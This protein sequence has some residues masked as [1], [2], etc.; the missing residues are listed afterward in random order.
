MQQP[1]RAE[2]EDGT[3]QRARRLLEE[4]QQAIYRRTDRLFSGLLIFQWLASIG[5][6][7]WISPQTWIGQV[8]R[9]HIHVWAAIFLGA[10]IISLPVY[11]SVKAPGRTSTRHTIAVAQMLIGALLIHLTGGR[12]ETH[13]HVFGS[14][15]LL[16]F[17]RDWRV[18]VTGSLVVAADH[19][20]R[21]VLW[22]QSVFGVF[23]ASYWRWVE[24]TFWVTFEDVFLINSCIRSQQEM[25]GIAEQ[26]AMLE[27][28]NE[29]VEAAV[30]ERTAE[31]DIS[32]K[33]FRSLS[34]ASPVGIL[35]VDAAGRS[36]YANERWQAITGRRFADGTDQS[37][38]VSLHLDDGAATRQAWDHCRARGFDFA[39]EAR[40]ATPAGVVRWV[41]LQ[42]KPLF[43]DAAELTGYVIVSEDITERKRVEEQ[44]VESEEQ[45]R[46]AFDHAPIGMALASPAG[47][48]IRVN[49]VLCEFTGYTEQ[50]LLATTF[51][52]I[53]HPD[54]LADDM[55][56]VR[57]MLAD[58]IRFYRIEKRYFHKQGHTVWVMLN[59]SLIRDAQGDPLHFIAEIEDIT[60]RKTVE[61]ELQW[62]RDAALESARLKSEFL[63]NMS[64]E[65]RTPM[66]G[67]IGMTRLALDTD[68]DPEQRDYLETAMTSA[69]SLLTIIND[70]LD[71]SK[72]EAG[73][74]DID[75]TDFS[76]R[77]CIVNTIKP[78][79]V[80]AHA[81]HLEVNLDIAADVPDALAGDPI[82]VGQIIA[83]LAS[84]AIKFTEAG[85]VTLQVKARQRTPQDI[86]MH[87]V[88][89][90]T[91]IGIRPE[92]QQIIF[93]SFTQ[94]DGS[95][96]RKYG[97]TGLGLAISASLVKLMGGE[98]WVESHPG[99]GSEFHFTLNFGIV[100]SEIAQTT[101][102]LPASLLGRR[103][104]VVDD[105]ATNRRILAHMLADWGMK[106]A[107]AEDGQAALRMMQEALATGDPFSLIMVDSRMPGMDG[108]AV[109]EQIRKIP[110]FEEAMMMMLTSAQQND[111]ISRCKQLG[112][113]AY[114][115]KP[116]IESALLEAVLKTLGRRP[117]FNR[118][119]VRATDGQESPNLRRMRVLLV[120]DNLINQ[121]VATRLLEKR[122]CA[123]ELAATGKEAL[124]A[125][126]RQSFDIILM[127][128][129]MPD[130]NGFEAT[131]AIRE[132]EKST[133]SHVPI[134]AMTAHVM[135]GDKER[136]LET[137]MDGY[138]SKPIR[139]EELFSTI[140]ELVFAG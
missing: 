102:A 80:Q 52:A 104:L 34:A 137:G 135:K 45:F 42:A 72:I 81:K 46:K 58:E 77:E 113:G 99:E 88:F 89:S 96:T 85:E 75:C 11:L 87:F 122:G 1:F 132:R 26:R 108:F 5:I 94:A 79:V 17:Y 136:C 62:A 92:V 101:P 65:I 9:T 57:K 139:P 40:M 12:I 21:G 47:A 67:I 73:K 28:T 23:G 43:S 98:I 118:E 15:A 39:R 16:A 3:R 131:R 82:R 22:P 86:C 119:M 59:I 31:L 97:G 55:E 6:S 10:A 7:L 54:D 64:H 121:K 109:S 129:Q 35:Q 112:I 30:L 100:A 84:N 120:E 66:N 116:I 127:D 70:I 83:N 95:T 76:L 18:L 114:I 138:V 126:A 74:L 27:A 32:E 93:M 133:G 51:Q 130:M 105:N 111:D 8:A 25:C 63:A 107:M 13:F 110:A 33:K 14:L 19:F 4:H 36:V 60:Q 38:L 49:R 69:H 61:R 106:P 50:E 124:A 125:L 128:V 53:T 44:L 103:V 48:W 71:F 68:L 41:S 91:G 56:N 24:H 37:W 140:N 20:L 2:I 90:D 123:V 78:F 115:V 117:A 134:V 29:R